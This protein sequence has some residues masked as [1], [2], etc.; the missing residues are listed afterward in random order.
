MKIE[1]SA[2]KEEDIKLKIHKSEV[3]LVNYRNTH[4]AMHV[5]FKIKF[6]E[7]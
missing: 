4:G 7:L 2:K 1:N 6:N 5:F 3:L